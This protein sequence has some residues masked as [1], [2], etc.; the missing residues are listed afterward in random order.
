MVRLNA[1]HGRPLDVQRPRLRGPRGCGIR[2]DG[3]KIN[4]SQVLQ[5]RLSASEISENIR[6]VLD[7]AGAVVS[8]QGCLL[9]GRVRVLTKP[10]CAASKLYGSSLKLTPLFFC[11]SHSPRV[12]CLP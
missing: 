10:R 3:R 7:A 11:I 8:N 2:F 5:L 1:A 9:A 6:A 4:L 12:P